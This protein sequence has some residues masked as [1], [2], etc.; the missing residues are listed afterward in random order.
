MSEE[1]ALSGLAALEARLRQ[2]L[3]WLDLPAS[4]WVKPRF[5][6][7]A[8]VLDV[9]IIGGGMAGLAL[10]AEL[11]HLGVDAVI[12]ISPR[13]VLKGRGQPPPVCKRCALPST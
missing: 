3:D 2:D 7:G 9:A 5:N 6:E 13:P 1:N 11:R 4:Q 12:S 10:A 8:P